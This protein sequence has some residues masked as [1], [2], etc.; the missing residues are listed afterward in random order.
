MKIFTNNLQGQDPYKLLMSTV[1]PRPIAWVSTKN[2]NGT[3]N[4]APFSNFTFLCHRA[5][6]V[7]IGMGRKP[8]NLEIMKDTEK[9]IR[10]TNEFVINVPSSR[11]LDAV[12][13]SSVDYEYG[14]S[15]SEILKLTTVKSE[16][17]DV[18]RLS[19]VEISMECKLDQILE[20]GP[21]KFKYHFITG[22]ISVFHINDEL[23]D[24]DNRIN[25]VA[26]DP[27]MRIGGPNYAQVGKTFQKTYLTKG[28]LDK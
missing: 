7:G 14:I 20:I 1:V 18:E 16:T 25:T 24:S 4:L 3:L 23:M 17:V 8:D 15:E 9:N 10:R 6:M 19:D 26:V 5:L 21:K 13:Q 2:E 11:H 27:L 28:Y 22:F 12:H